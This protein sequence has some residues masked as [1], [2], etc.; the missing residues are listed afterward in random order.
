MGKTLFH[1]GRRGIGEGDSEDIRRGDL[2]LT[3]DICDAQSQD[4][5]LARPRS[6]NDHDRSLDRIHCLFLC[7]VQVRVLGVKN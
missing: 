1:I 6:C 2:R 7:R 3:E 4:L 5:C